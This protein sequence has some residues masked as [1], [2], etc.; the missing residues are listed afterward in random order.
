MIRLKFDLYNP[1][2]KWKYGGEFELPANVRIWSDNVIQKIADTQKD[3]VPEAI[4][5]R[6]YHM[7]ISEITDPMPA[8]TFWCHM[9][10]AQENEDD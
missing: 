8:G 10:P 4:T 2:G 6:Y 9:F 3:V 1:T 7:V 5:K